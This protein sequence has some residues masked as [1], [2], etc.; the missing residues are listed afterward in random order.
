MTHEG[1]GLI[2]GLFGGVR[3][4]RTTNLIF[5]E[6][7]PGLGKTTTAV[8]LASR[9]QAVHPRVNLLLETQPGH[10]LN[11]GGDLLPA[12][13][14]TGEE[15]FERYTPASF[16]RESLERWRTFVRFASASDTI[17]VLDSYPFQNAARILLQLDMGF[18][19]IY[20]YVGQVEA[21]AAPLQPALIYLAHWDAEEM[22]RH[23]SQIS[24]QR[25][26]EWTNYVIML[27]K[28][29]P[30]AR[31]RQLE[32][33]EGVLE[34]LRDYKRLTDALARRT[35]MPGVVIEAGT[36][37]WEERYREIERFLELT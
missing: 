37:N 1:C 20:E 22:T 25:G 28:Q 11:V 4:M 12:G 31:A 24:A 9:L 14:V 33:F 5:V 36:G 27:M 32:G 7:L 29:A 19:G 8:W 10:P 18:D 30:Y 3:S 16:V 15:F 35:P 26:R 17:T 34:F 21:L 13:D 6:G 23:F 2:Q